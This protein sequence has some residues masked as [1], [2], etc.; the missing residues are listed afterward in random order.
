MS[1]SS[2]PSSVTAASKAMLA[3]AAAPAVATT[4]TVAAPT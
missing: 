4:S 2:A 3:G 1:A